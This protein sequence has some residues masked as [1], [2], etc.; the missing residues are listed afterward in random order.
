MRLTVLLWLGPLWSLVLSPWLHASPLDYALTPIAIADNVWLLEGKQE[1]FSRLNG[2]NIVNTGFILTPAGVVVIDTG[3]SVRYGK[4]MREVIASLTDKPVVLVL[5][6]HHHPDHVLGNL[7]FA[8]EAPIAALPATLQQLEQEGDAVAETLYT[9]VGDWMR[10][11]QVQLPNQTLGPDSLNTGIEIGGQRLR[12]LALR[13]HSG[14]DLA[15]LH[16]PSGTLFAG[17]LV[18]HQRALTTPHTPG[19][20][21]W[22]QE[23]ELLARQP[24]NQLVPGH[25][26]LSLGTAAI[27]QTQAYLGWL[28]QLLQQ[29]AQAGLSMTEAMQLPIPAHFN[30]IALSRY[31]LQRSVAHLYNQYEQQA[32]AEPSSTSA[33]AS[34]TTK[35]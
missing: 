9:L 26:P 5:N 19:L 35:E 15:I 11:T 25:G 7:A 3:P 16:E 30:G 4:A 18:F 28:D 12:L 34:S 17:D 23:L 21:L 13:G 27:E 14:A 20:A 33:Q 31:E 32:F 1:A 29:A 24:F 10:D 6:T 22:Q 8:E 2:G